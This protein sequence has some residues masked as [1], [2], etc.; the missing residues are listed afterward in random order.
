V[1]AVTNHCCPI[2]PGTAAL[3]VSELFSNAVLYGPPSG[4]VLAGYCLWVRGARLAVCDG[5][6]ETTPSHVSQPKAS[7]QVGLYR[8]HSTYHPRP[9]ETSIPSH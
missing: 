2:D 5:G 1:Y 8:D 4:R 3:A 6:G 7:P 9:G